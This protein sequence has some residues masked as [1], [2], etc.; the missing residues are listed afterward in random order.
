MR[1]GVAERPRSATRILG[2]RWRMTAEWAYS[3]SLSQLGI[4]STGSVN[5]RVSN[6]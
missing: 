1:R 4:Q 3:H 6:A 2:P 5:H